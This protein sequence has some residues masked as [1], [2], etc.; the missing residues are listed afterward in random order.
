MGLDR[1]AASRAVGRHAVVADSA[2]PI[3]GL[4]QTFLTPRRCQ[5]CPRPCVTY[6]FGLNN[7]PDR[8]DGAKALLHTLPY[9]DAHEASPGD[10]RFDG[11]RR[12]AGTAPGNDGG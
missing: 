2:N 3:E 4:Q 6:V 8:V 12:M 10:P 9:P 7:K 1:H 11:G 5:G